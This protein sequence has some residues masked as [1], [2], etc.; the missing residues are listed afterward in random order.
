[1][2][3]GRFWAKADK[4]KNQINANKQKLLTG[5]RFIMTQVTIGQVEPGSN[6]QSIQ[7][8]RV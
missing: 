3:L 4:A 6:P 2:I 5:E 1:M 8:R 7:S